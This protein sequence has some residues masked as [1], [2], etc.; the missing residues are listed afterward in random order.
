MTPI[1]NE[2]VG[3][4]PLYI[5]LM[6]ANTL[7]GTAKSFWRALLAICI[8]ALKMCFDSAIPDL[9]IY[10]KKHTFVKKFSFLACVLQKPNLKRSPMGESLIGMSIPN[11]KREDREAKWGRREPEKVHYHFSHHHGQEVAC[12]CRMVGEVIRNV[13]QAFHLKEKGHIYVPFLIPHWRKVSTFPGYTGMAPL[14]PSIHSIPH[15]CLRA[16]LSDSA[17]RCCH[18]AHV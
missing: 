13:S 18:F 14:Y 7:E 1:V 16:I 6:I 15:L 9:G 12:Y 2:Y 4:W 10:P 8:K 17:V 3:K 5:F 11:S